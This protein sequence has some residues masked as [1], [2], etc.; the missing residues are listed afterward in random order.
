MKQNSRGCCDHQRMELW[1]P[2]NCPCPIPRKPGD[3]KVLLWKRSGSGGS[4]AAPTFGGSPAAS[5][6]SCSTVL[7]QGTLVTEASPRLQ[8]LG[9]LTLQ[10]KL[11]A[12]GT[13]PLRKPH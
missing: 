13:G 11:T 10:R 8:S 1:H 7:P 3:P 9:Q 5:L 4:P 6:A 12:K 2:Q